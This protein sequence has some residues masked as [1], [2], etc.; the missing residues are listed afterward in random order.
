MTTLDDVLRHDPLHGTEAD[1]IRACCR[2]K[3]FR[4][5]LGAI[6]AEIESQKQEL[7]TP[8][9]LRVLTALDILGSYVRA[10]TDAIDYAPRE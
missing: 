6:A 8:E 3:G 9:G 4:S 10:A 2:E 5:V 1:L 7:E